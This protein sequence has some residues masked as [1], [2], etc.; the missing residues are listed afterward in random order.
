[1]SDYKAYY[2][3]NQIWCKDCFEE[4]TKICDDC[5]R[6][7]HQ[8]N[9]CYEKG[10]IAYYSYYC[11]KNENHAIMPY[12]TEGKPHGLPSL[13]STYLLRLSKAGL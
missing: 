8:N 5:G 3:D 1:M 10:K 13:E 6:L 11:G 9:P 7:V 4:H 12:K 2:H